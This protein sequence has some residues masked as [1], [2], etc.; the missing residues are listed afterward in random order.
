M[1]D[2]GRLIKSLW[3]RACRWDGI[4]VDCKFA[5]WSLDNPYAERYNRMMGLF[6]NAWATA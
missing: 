3:I 6:L 2:T 5:I 4:S 1:K